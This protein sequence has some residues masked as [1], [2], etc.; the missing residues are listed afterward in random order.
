MN[1]Y[2]GTYTTDAFHQFNRSIR[3]TNLFFNE[4]DICCFLIKIMRDVFFLGQK[5]IVRDLSAI[6]FLGSKYI[7]S[8][9]RWNFFFNCL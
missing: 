5:K 2:Y 7:F 9:I 8:I 6:S 1:L 4:T 3:D